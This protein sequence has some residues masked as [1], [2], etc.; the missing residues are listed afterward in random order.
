MCANPRLSGGWHPTLLL[1][2]IC[3]TSGVGIRSDA[4]SAAQPHEGEDDS[5]PP[6]RLWPRRPVDEGH[7]SGAAYDK[8]SDADLRLETVDAHLADDAHRIV[9]A[10]KRG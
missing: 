2:A 3:S 7:G 5:A 6:L 8:P 1:C 4:R 10:L 9:D